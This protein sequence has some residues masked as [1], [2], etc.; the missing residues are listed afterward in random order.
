MTFQLG[1]IGKIVILYRNENPIKDS[2]S[3]RGKWYLVYIFPTV[4]IVQICYF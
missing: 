3:T 4:H 2:P 1:H